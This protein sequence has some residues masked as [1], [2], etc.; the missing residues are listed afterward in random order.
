MKEKSNNILFL[1][2][3]LTP[4]FMDSLRY[5]S[6]KNKYS[7]I[8]VVYLQVFKNIKLK[9]TNNLNFV[10]KQ[11]VKY[12]SDLLIF[13]NKFIW[14]GLIETIIWDCFSPKRDTSHLPLISISDSN[15]ILDNMH[16]SAMVTAIPP[17][18]QSWAEIIKPLL[19]RFKQHFCNR[20]SNSKSIRGE[21]AIFLWIIS[22]YS[23]PA[24]SLWSLE[25]ALLPS[26]ITRSF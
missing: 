19:I 5:Y 9:N 25:R 13:A 14:F 20:F 10:A 7:F 18:E 22:K 4:Y 21:P 24:K 23:L 11:E 26:K 12:R 8:Q 6:E 3:E 17:S 15:P 1:Y 2:A 16:D